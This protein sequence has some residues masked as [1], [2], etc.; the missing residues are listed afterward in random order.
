MKAF[1]CTNSLLNGSDQR[2]SVNFGCFLFYYQ[3]LVFNEFFE[4]GTDVLAL[5][6]PHEQ[7]ELVNTGTRAQQLLDEH[8]A[9]ESRRTGDEHRFT[10]IKLN[11]TRLFHFILFFVCSFFNSQTADC[12][13]K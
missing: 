2:E 8:F 5:G 12:V 13:T 4:A 10:V 1:F 11:D 9:H 7:A 3:Y 6:R